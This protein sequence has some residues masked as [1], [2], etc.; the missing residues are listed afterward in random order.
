MDRELRRARGGNPSS[1]ALICSA[2]CFEPTRHCAFVCDDP[3]GSDDPVRPDRD[4][5]RR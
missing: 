2:M 4:A 1:I 5:V 3:A